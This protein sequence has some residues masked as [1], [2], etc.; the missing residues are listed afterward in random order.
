MLRISEIFGPTIQGEGP[1]IGKKCIFI[2]FY[3]CDYRCSFCDQKEYLMIPISTTIKYI[4]EKISERSK[5]T[6]KIV[7]TGG[8]PCIQNEKLM[9][10]LIKELIFR[11]YE[12]AIETQGSKWCSWLCLISLI[13]VSPKLYCYNYNLF[14]TIF[15]RKCYD[16]NI[17]NK[18]CIKIVIF[19]DNNIINQLI[20]TKK[21]REYYKNVLFYISIGNRFLRIKNKSLQ[22]K[23]IFND[24]KKILSYILRDEGF[25]DISILPQMH[26]LLWGS[27]IKM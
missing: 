6:K 22:R 5:S 18:L 7:I 17:I 10:E 27:F 16:Y 13:V 14:D 9:E 25:Q 1:W 4:L 8:N 26:V 2:R 15:M 24:Y 21:I 12:I 3:G 23:L 19:A 11:N 20:K